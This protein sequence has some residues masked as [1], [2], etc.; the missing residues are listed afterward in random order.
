VYPRRH[1]GARQKLE[2][3]RDY[4]QV[5]ASRGG[6]DPQLYTSDSQ[7]LPI[8][9]LNYI[10]AKINS[11]DDDMFGVANANLT[12]LG[13]FFTNANYQTLTDQVKIASPWASNDG[14]FIQNFN[15]AGLFAYAG[16]Y[17]NPKILYGNSHNVYNMLKKQFDPNNSNAKNFLGLNDADA[18][19]ASLT[20]W[21]LTVSQDG[22]TPLQKYILSQ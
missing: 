10:N 12:A 1:S 22:V 19:N 7:R 16:N 17:N 14:T 5:K 2:A 18:F 11:S 6:G 15:A 9:L 13:T 20:L 21:G 8:R 4:S 3:H